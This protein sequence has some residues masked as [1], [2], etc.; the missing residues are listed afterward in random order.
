MV[1]HSYKLKCIVLNFD[2]SYKCFSALLHSHY[3]GDNYISV[4]GY[5]MIIS[6]CLFVVVLFC[7]LLFRAEGVAYGSSQAMHSY[8]HSN[9]RSEPCLEPTPQLTAIPDAQPTEQGQ[10]V[11]P[12]LHGYWSGL[13]PLS[14]N[15]NSPECFLANLIWTSSFPWNN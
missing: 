1:L 14:H 15:G 7:F 11:N 4:S 5:F 2:F 12:H 3:N 13:L 8:S 10:G 9:L 6:E